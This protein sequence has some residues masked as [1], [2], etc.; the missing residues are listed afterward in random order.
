MN[1]IISRENQILTAINNVKS[2][3]IIFFRYE[4][5]PD[6]GY[7]SKIISGVFRSTKNRTNQQNK[8][9]QRPPIPKHFHNKH[10]VSKYTEPLTVYQLS[11]NSHE[12]EKAPYDVSSS[13]GSRQHLTET[14]QIQAT[15]LAQQQYHHTSVKNRPYEAFIED[16]SAYNTVPQNVVKVNPIITYTQNTIGENILSSTDNPRMA[17]LTETNSIRKSNNTLVTGFLQELQGTTQQSQSSSQL[18]STPDNVDVDYSIISLFKILNDF[19]R[20]KEAI[21]STPDHQYYVQ[22]GIEDGLDANTYNE[23]HQKGSLIIIMIRYKY[24][25]TTNVSL[26]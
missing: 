18:P 16:Y 17:H 11:T 7:I 23:Q 13:Q 25:N 14:T 6:D 12:I 10:H 19:K 8:V 22:S 2:L 3:I 24:T 26:S 1:A 15:T 21:G 9:S 4:L 5:D 20:A